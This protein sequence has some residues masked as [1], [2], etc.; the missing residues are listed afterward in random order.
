MFGLGMGELL[1]IFFIALIFLGPKKL[2]ELA[3]GL[4]KAV[5]DFNRARSGM[6]DEIQKEV[7]RAEPTEVLAAVPV[8][9]EVPQVLVQTIVP[10]DSAKESHPPTRVN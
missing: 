1:L 5:R 2:P 8:K 4:G 3:Q 10:S 9:E 6:M 7:K